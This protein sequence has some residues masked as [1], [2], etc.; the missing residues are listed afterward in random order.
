MTKKNPDSAKGPGVEG[1]CSPQA[2]KDLSGFI[3]TTIKLCL[4]DLLKSLL[5]ESIANQCN[6]E[7]AVAE[8]IKRHCGAHA[9]TTP[10]RLAKKGQK[11]DS[12]KM[13]S[14]PKAS[15]SASCSYNNEFEDISE[16]EEFSE[17]AWKTAGSG[18][19]NKRKKPLSPPK[20]PNKKPHMNHA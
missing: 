5:P 17:Q 15:T 20:Q 13:N 19:A 8:T 10:D 12:N 1:A 9:P 7:S 14:S 16:E 2:E 18:S 6:I 11:K 4:I 3:A